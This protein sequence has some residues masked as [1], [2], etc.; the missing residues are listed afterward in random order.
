MTSR[1]RKLEAACYFT[2]GIIAILLNVFTDFT[3][4]RLLFKVFPILFIRWKISHY[5][6]KENQDGTLLLSSN[7]QIGFHI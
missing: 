1:N 5:K 4:T 7:V 3:T 2:P 6:S